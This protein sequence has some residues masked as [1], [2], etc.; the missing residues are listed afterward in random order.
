MKSRKISRQSRSRS[1]YT[2]STVFVELGGR[3]SPP[4]LLQSKVEKILRS[5]DV[6]QY[7]GQGVKRGIIAAW[8]LIIV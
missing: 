2:I 1:V 6:V 8:P 3:G 4:S 7:D 5:K